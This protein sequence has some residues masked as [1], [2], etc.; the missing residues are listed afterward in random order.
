MIF[1]VNYINTIFQQSHLGRPEV[2][3]PGDEAS[4]GVNKRLPSFPLLT[5]EAK[6]KIKERRC[7]H[8]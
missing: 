5:P 7:C 3:N 4:F 8:A 6:P 1:I 2:G